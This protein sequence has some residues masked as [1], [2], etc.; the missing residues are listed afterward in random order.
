MDHQRWAAG[1]GFQRLPV[2]RC[3]QH[4]VHP[5]FCT[6]RVAPGDV[7]CWLVMPEWT[8]SGREREIELDQ[9]REAEELLGGVHSWPDGSSLLGRFFASSLADLGLVCSAA[10]HSQRGKSSLC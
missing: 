9:R 10:L 4:L 7:E 1:I 8:N 3:W 5:A 6:G 2:Q